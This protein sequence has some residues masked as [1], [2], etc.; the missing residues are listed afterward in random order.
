MVEGTLS[1]HWYLGALYSDLLLYRCLVTLGQHFKILFLRSFPF[2]KW[3]QLSTV[4]ELW[5]FEII[6]IHTEMYKVISNIIFLQMWCHCWF[7]HLSFHKCDRWHFDVFLQTEL[8]ARPLREHTPASNCRWTVSVVGSPHI[9]VGHVVYEWGVPDIWI[10]SCG[11]G[12]GGT[13][14]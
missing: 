4:V 8:L 3:V 13:K 12:G 10:G 1:F 5:G 6:Q 2:M 9:S 11:G 7:G 14:Y